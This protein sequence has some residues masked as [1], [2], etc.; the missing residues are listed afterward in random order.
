MAVFLDRDGTICRDT[1]Y[2]AR[3][4]QFELLTGV[5]EGIRLLNKLDMKVIVVTNQSGIARGY[6]SEEDLKNINRKMVSE[7]S[8]KGAKI[9]AIYYC[10]HHPNDNCNCR[11]PKIGMLEKAARDFNLDLRVC[12]ILGDKKIDIEAG[13][14]A[15]CTSILILSPEIEHDAKAEYVATNLCEAA[16]LISKMVQERNI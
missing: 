13:H 5:A 15:K 9:D 10:P 1:H 16:W 11:K 6:F 2:I 4:E 3:P 7:L 8:K 14:N 12:F